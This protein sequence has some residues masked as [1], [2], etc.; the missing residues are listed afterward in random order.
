MEVVDAAAAYEGL[1]GPRGRSAWPLDGGVLLAWVAYRVAVD[2]G[3]PGERLARHLR[4]FAGQRFL[5][6]RP[7]GLL[8]EVP[9]P[10][11]H[12]SRSNRPP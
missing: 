11:E 1:R 12:R 6:Q 10:R 3:G 8:R 9:R 4:Y 2:T 7:D 5:D